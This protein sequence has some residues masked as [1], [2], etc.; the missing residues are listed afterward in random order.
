M[1]SRGQSFLLAS[2][3]QWDSVSS[4]RK[5]RASFILSQRYLQVQI[6]FK[7]SGKRYRIVFWIS[8]PQ[9]LL[10]RLLEILSLCFRTGIKCPLSLYCI[11][12]L[13]IQ[14]L[15]DV[16]TPPLKPEPI[17]L[18]IY[19]LELLSNAFQ[20]LIGLNV[21]NIQIH[22]CPTDQFSDIYLIVHWGLPP[23]GISYTSGT[24]KC[25]HFCVF[26]VKLQLPHSIL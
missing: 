5:L 10:V 19:I 15:Y 9:L 6:S 14:M 26:S 1:S 25:V 13:C 8:L 24:H 20:Q 18:I 12:I 16:H 21:L 7:E 17:L 11:N 22:L 2:N 4:I 23:I 3:Q